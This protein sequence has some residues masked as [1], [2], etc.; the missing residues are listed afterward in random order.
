LPAIESRIQ[1]DDPVL[2]ENAAAFDRLVDDLRRR[3]RRALEGGG[4][5][6]RAR[7]VER[8]K[9]PVRERIDLLLDPFSPFLE[10]SPLAAWGL[11][12]TRSP[13]PAS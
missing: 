3:H 12:G 2:A 6:L 1:P 8:G 10:L 11:Y 5:A 4:A 13:R 7:H 9:I